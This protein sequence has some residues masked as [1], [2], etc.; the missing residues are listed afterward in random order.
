MSTSPLVNTKSALVF[1]G[2]TIFG[3]LMM[4]SPSENG[5]MLDRLTNRAG[6]Q[7]EPA[8]EAAAVTATQTQPQAVEP[9]DPDAGWGG[10][11]DPVFGDYASAETPGSETPLEES[12]PASVSSPQQARRTSALSQNT[13]GPVKADSLGELVPRDGSGEAPQAEAVVTSRSINIELQ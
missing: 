13:G 11:G 9:L 4:V 12:A 1:A 8:P 5:G 10:T 6:Q 7:S 2:I 3:T